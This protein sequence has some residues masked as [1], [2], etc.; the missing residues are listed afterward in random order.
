VLCHPEF[1]AFKN[2][3]YMNDIR[4]ASLSLQKNRPTTKPDFPLGTVKSPFLSLG[5]VLYEKYISGNTF[6]IDP[7]Y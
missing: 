7:V 1:P 3:K 5:L 2:P 4:A 6:N